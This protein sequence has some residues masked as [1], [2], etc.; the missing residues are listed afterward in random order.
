MVSPEMIYILADSRYWNGISVIPIEVM[1]SFFLFM[2]SFAV[3]YEIYRG[4]TKMIAIGTLSAAIINIVL[5]WFLVPRY[6]MYGAAIATSI[7]Y[8][9]LYLFHEFYAK[10]IEN[11][12]YQFSTSFFFTA[13][14]LVLS[15][16]IVFPF[17]INLWP[18]RW[19]IAILMGSFMLLKLKRN[20]V[21]F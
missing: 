3:N 20:K 8:L 19:I 21:I 5:N 17:T 11:S 2:Y 1:T 7:S 4:K 16:C 18:I 15:A 12:E 9:A 10:R 6:S 14:V 13:F